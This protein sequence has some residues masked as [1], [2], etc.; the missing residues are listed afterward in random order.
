MRR[1]TAAASR[2]VWG[3][4]P[5][6]ARGVPTHCR[7]VASRRGALDRHS[8]HSASG[9]FACSA[10]LLSPGHGSAR[11]ESSRP[12]PPALCRADSR[13]RASSSKG[14]VLT[15]EDL[16]LWAAGP[17]VLGH[18]YS[19]PASEPYDFSPLQEVGGGVVV[20]EGWAMELMTAAGLKSTGT[21]N[22]DAF[23]Y[24]LLESGWVFCVACDGHGDGG[25]VVSERIARTIPFFL[26]RQF[27]SL[28]FEKALV[29]AFLSA[30]A[31]LEQS[32][33]P[34]QAFAGST[35]IAVCIHPGSGEAW[36]AHAGDSPLV[37]G[38]LATGKV[39]FRTG[40]HKAHDPSEAERL[41]KRGAQ[42]ICKKYDDGEILSRVFIPRTGVPGLAMSRSLGDGCLKKYGVTAEP[43]VQ[44]VSS[45]WRGC[46]AP[47]A[48]LCSDGLSDMVNLKDALTTVSIRARAGKD[49]KLSVAKLIR[50]AQ[51]V[52]IEEEGDYCDDITLLLMGPSYAHAA[53]KQAGAAKTVP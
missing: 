49:L 12:G 38:D 35:A 17:S 50:K 25:E 24:T 2:A 52:W 53:R 29:E 18:A 3:A 14:S 5:V 6:A 8:W 4:E 51:H 19:R 48:L 31:D 15:S 10:T 1:T 40:D 41:K 43:D 11:A 39:A 46:E 13:R 28:G 44:D 20:P 33:S 27:P 9:I 32:F 30:Q 16:D 23:S 7:V 36:V 21:L 26:S 45:F 34:M 42:V 37:I 22:Q 47:I